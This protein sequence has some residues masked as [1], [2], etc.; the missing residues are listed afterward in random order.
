MAD[1]VVNVFRLINRRG[2]FT[3]DL[4]VLYV[5]KDTGTMWHI[6][7]GGTRAYLIHYGSSLQQSIDR[8]AADSHFMIRRITG[9]LLL[10][11]AGLFQSEAVGRVLFTGVEGQVAWETHLD[12]LI[13]QKSDDLDEVTRNVNGWI[14]ALC[15]HTVLRRAADDAHLALSNPH[16]AMIFVYRGLEWLVVGSGIKWEDLAADLEVP[17]SAIR[18]LKKT[19]NVEGIRHATKS[20]LKLRALAENYGTWV[21]ALFDAL[22]ATRAR[23]EDAYEPMNSDQVAM[24]V[25]RAMPMVPYE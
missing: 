13:T 6:T 25:M 14:K 19:A 22:T 15:A 16:E 8:E 12:R 17:V 5:E 10:G 2:Y 20:G 23:L 11:G 3:P 21:C 18:D 7:C 9:A 4:D 24:A 1:F